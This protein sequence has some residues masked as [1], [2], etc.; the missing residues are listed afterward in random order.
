MMI[1]EKM[2]P[3]PHTPDLSPDRG[4]HYHRGIDFSSDRWKEKNNINLQTYSIGVNL[5]NKK[6]NINLSKKPLKEGVST[7]TT[8]RGFSMEKTYQSSHKQINSNILSK[9]LEVIE[10]ISP[11]Q[12]EACQKIIEEFTQTVKTNERFRKKLGFSEIQAKSM[13][14]NNLWAVPEE[15]LAKR[16]VKAVVAPFVYLGKKVYTL[17]F[18]NN[19]GKKNFSKIYNN[20]QE[21]KKFDKI[22]GQYNNVTGL[23]NSVEKWEN[24]YR[25]RFGFDK[26]KSGEEFLMPEEDLKRSLRKRAFDSINPNI[27]KYSAKSLSTGN[28]V[29]SGIVGS[30]FYGIDAY[31]TTMKLS[32]DKKTSKKEGKVK[33]A[34]QLI[35]ITL[36]SYFTATAFGVFKKQT[37]K[38]MPFALAVAGSM[39]LASELF[40][41]LLVGNPILPTSKRKLEE[42]NEKNKKSNNIVLKFGRMLSGESK[43]TDNKPQQT[44]TQRIVLDDKY[45]KNRYKSKIF[46]NEHVHELE[47][48]GAVPKTFKKTE[49][50]NLLNVLE[51]MDPKLN[52]Y[53]KENILQNLVKKKTI[54]ADEA[55]KPF[56]EAVKDLNEIEI[57][58]YTTRKEKIKKAILAPIKW[59]KNIFV[60]GFNWL[61][62]VFGGKKDTPKLETNV[63]KIKKM[64]FEES[65]K[66]EL[67]NF[68]QS[69]TFTQKSKLTDDQKVEAFATSF[70]HLKEKGFNDEIQGIQNS[71]EWLKKSVKMDKNDKSDVDVLVK[72]ILDNKDNP[73][74]KKHLQSINDNMN[75]MCFTAYAKDYAD[76]DASKYAVANNYTARLLSTTFLVFDAY[77]LTM[78]HSN[79]KKKSVDNGTQYATQ[80][81][82]R[83]AMSS[84]II[85]ATNTVFQSLYNSSLAGALSLTALSSTTV[86]VLSRFAVGNSIVPRSQKELLE[87]EER[88][89]KNPVLKVTSVMVGKSMK[90]NEH[91][92]K[93]SK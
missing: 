72:K 80:E 48:K 21:N 32:D 24:G 61:K 17:I 1:R 46:G 39:V 49:L 29:A 43:T 50:L 59:V 57:G 14:K 20:I 73:E 33:F 51:E 85:N 18:D 63:E 92:V 34:Q 78:L 84:Y 88:N 55:K 56:E 58:E 67:E 2:S 25:T 4:S 6:D 52:T 86:A 38:S 12:H 75:K 37:N 16:F 40:G 11:K 27:S 81:V 3:R 82:T 76:Y 68:K 35:R 62:K 69:K 89:K 15:S 66:I 53:Y 41:R 26:I 19:F 93:A 83:T 31:N 91:Q 87:Q 8:F 71:L 13:D 36:A 64:G 70:M 5:Q 47:F 23:F 44:E 54:T 28:R 77:N 60:K 74:V 65:Y 30:I 7:Q 22:T 90:K 9:S 45:I 42:I 10:H 79:D